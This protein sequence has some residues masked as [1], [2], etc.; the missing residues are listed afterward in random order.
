MPTL[1]KQY[2][3]ACSEIVAAYR[4]AGEPWPAESKA[5]AIW[6]INTELWKPHRGRMIAQCANDISRA[7]REEYYTDPQGRQVRVKHAARYRSKPE[8]G[9]KIGQKTLWDDI[10]TA[11]YEHMS[12]AFALRRCQI[13]GECKQLKSDI[14][15]YNDN[16][17]E[18]K[19]IQGMFD[20]R[21]DIADSEQPTEYKPKQPR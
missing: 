11:G 5:I 8:P 20:F 12:R 19:R 16:N 4:A 18:G 15:S 14:D 6:A 17:V 3:T 10:R 1:K 21:D 13:V 9:E 7:M 2:T